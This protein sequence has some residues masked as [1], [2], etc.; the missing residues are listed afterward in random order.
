M[1]SVLL[2]MGVI[3]HAAIP[4]LLIAGVLSLYLPRFWNNRRHAMY[5]TLFSKE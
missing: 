3:L 4:V 2:H 1:M 5:D